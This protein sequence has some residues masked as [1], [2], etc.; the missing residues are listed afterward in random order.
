MVCFRRLPNWEMDT[1]LEIQ[2]TSHFPSQIRKPFPVLQYYRH[3]RWGNFFLSVFFRLSLLEFSIWSVFQ[4][5]YFDHR[6]LE[7]CSFFTCGTEFRALALYH[8]VWRRANAWN[9]IFVIFLRWNSTLLL[10]NFICCTS[11]PTL[12]HNLGLN[13][14]FVC[15]CLRLL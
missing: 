13:L 14:S 1:T 4:H 2:M 9:V 3:Q 10:P 12:H 15:L 11:P 8:S 7:H 5:R 6:I